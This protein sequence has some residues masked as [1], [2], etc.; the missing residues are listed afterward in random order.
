MFCTAVK[1]GR[2]SD[3]VSDSG[4]TRE[5]KKKKQLVIES[6]SAETEKDVGP[7]SL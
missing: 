7:C 6:T 4:K 5:K 1:L 3:N 2:Y